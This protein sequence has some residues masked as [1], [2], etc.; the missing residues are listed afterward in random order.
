MIYDNNGPKDAGLAEHFDTAFAQP[1]RA[2]FVRAGLDNQ[3]SVADGP[4]LTVDVMQR[5]EML[6]KLLDMGEG[7]LASAR[8]RLFGP[9]P[10]NASGATSQKIAGPPCRKDE[11]LG[12]IDHL[13]A[14]AQRLAQHATVLNSGL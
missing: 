12:L 14:R 1:M 10:E 2:G 7:A 6:A 4:P 3:T 13:A 8:E 11:L 9:W 5:L